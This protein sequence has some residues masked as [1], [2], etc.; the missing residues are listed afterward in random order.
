MKYPAQGA[1]F[2]TAASLSLQAI[3]FET[4]A[5]G[6]E[7]NLASR[8]NVLVIMADD[9]GWGD[10]SYTGTKDIRTPF[11]DQLAEEGMIFQQFYA[12]SPVCSPTRAAFLT[13]RYPPYVGVPGVIRTNPEVSWGYLAPDAITLPEMFARNGYNTSLIGK[14][15]LGLESPNLPNERGF[16]YFKG[17]L[18]DMMEDYYTHKRNGQ[19]FLRHNLQVIEPSGHATSLFNQW[20]VD[21]INSRKDSEEPFFLFL[22]H[23]APHDPVQPPPE[24][25]EKV[26]QREP[27]LSDKR[28]ALV[29]LIEHM[30][31]GIG[32]VVNALKANGFYDNTIIV[33]TSD[34][35]GLL[36]EEANTGPYRDGKGSMYEG[37]LLVPALVV[38]KNNIEAGTQSPYKAVTMDLFP[39]L[40]GACNI[41]IE[42]NIEAV[43]FLPIL[44]GEPSDSRQRIMFFSRREGGNFNGLTIQA[45]QHNDYKLLQNSPWEPMQLYNL[46]NDPFETNNLIYSQPEIR[47]MLSR[48]LMDFIQK[49]GQTPWQKPADEKTANFTH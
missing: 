9:L 8:P 34:N 5:G 12:N 44:K 10:V 13:G 6:H 28:A 38:W 3:P 21:Y 20:A 23:F 15:H 47:R 22:A 14:W 48:M 37:G 7:K 16:N 32:D 26:K 1:L 41:N 33:F 30:D 43:S 35:G 17:F 24:W 2:L 42:H 18:G 4:K 45:V 19:N 49:G 39:T 31:H 27:H 11:I 40:L 25:L 36:T 29:A 46:K